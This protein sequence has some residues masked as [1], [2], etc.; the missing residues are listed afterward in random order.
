MATSRYM[1]PELK[2]I[3]AYMHATV[4]TVH[5]CTIKEMKVRMYACIFCASVFL[6]IVRKRK[7]KQAQHHVNLQIQVTS[8]TLAL[9]VASLASQAIK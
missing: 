4:H 9:T 2:H 1:H 8:G 7:N 3:R 6:R 5:R